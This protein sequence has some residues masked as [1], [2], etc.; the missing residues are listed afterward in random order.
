MGNSNLTVAK[1]RWITPIP[2]RWITP[3]YNQYVNVDK[4][5]KWWITAPATSPYYVWVVNQYICEP[6]LQKS[7][8]NT[9]SR[10]RVQARELLRATGD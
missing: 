6:Q 3:I 2:D 1:R 5:W 10:E 4:L 7:C 9:G 8:Y